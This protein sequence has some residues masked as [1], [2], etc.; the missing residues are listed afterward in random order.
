MIFYF[1]ATGNS[2]FA[3][4]KLRSENETIVSIAKSYR[5]SHYTFDA[6]NEHNIGFVFPVYFFGIPYIVA[7][8]IHR[9]EIA[10]PYNAYV[11]LVLTCGGATGN[12][13]WAGT[14]EAA[15][16]AV[17]LTRPVPT[18]S[19]LIRTATVIETTIVMP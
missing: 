3:V 14:V 19:T 6:K 18:T 4:E 9:I 1:T 16:L 5:D 17:L 12:A 8:F 10:M 7:K 15:A 11:Y 13:A 2:F